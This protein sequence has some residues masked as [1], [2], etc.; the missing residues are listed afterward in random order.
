[1]PTQFTGLLAPWQRKYTPAGLP[2]FVTKPQYEKKCSYLRDKKVKTQER[3][4]EQDIVAI[5][6]ILQIII[7]FLL[8]HINSKIPSR[9]PRD[10]V[11][12]ALERDRK[13]REEREAKG[14]K[15]I[16]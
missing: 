7:I 12:E 13:A 2:P 4:E 6:I 10:W 14:G 8:L 15:R 3:R 1:M 9:S 5:I 11:E 16:L